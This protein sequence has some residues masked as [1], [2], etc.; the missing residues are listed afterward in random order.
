MTAREYLRLI[1]HLKGGIDV[2]PGQSVK[3]AV[4]AEVQSKLTD[5]SFTSAEDADKIIDTYS[6]GMKR[7][8]LIAMALIGNPDLVFLDE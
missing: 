1:A 3:E 7:K 2:A 5:I 8:V 6:G 4:E